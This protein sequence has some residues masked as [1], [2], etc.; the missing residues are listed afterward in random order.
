MTIRLAELI[1]EFGVP[2]AS[3][4]CWHDGE[5]HQE[6]GGLLNL[7]TGVEATADS[8]FQ[9]GSVT[10][11]W[12]TA[13]VMLLVEEGRL[14]LDTPVAEVLPGI[15]QDVTIEHLLT[16]TSG[17]DGDFFHDTG[18]GDDCLERYTAAIA[19]RPLTH[20]V[21]ATHSYSNGG[22]SVAGRVVE[23]V[24]GK[25]WDTALRD[26]L[27]TPLGLTRT[28]TLPEDV[29]RFRAATGHLGEA[30]TPT[31]TWGMMRSNSPAG[32]ICSTAPDLVRFG[33]SFVEGGPLSAESVREMTRPR[34]ELP[35]RVYGTHWGLGWILDTWD[36]TPILL[37]GGNTIGQAAMMWV[38][39]STGT[40]VAVLAN[41]GDTSGLFQAVAAGLFPE[42]AGLTPPGPALPPD[43]PSEAGIAGHAGVYERTGARITVREDELVYENT[44][45]FADLEPPVSLELV[46][47][48]EH[49]FL[50][51]R[52]GTRLWAPGA[53]Y[54][55]RDGSPYLYFGVR[56]TPK[57]P[58]APGATP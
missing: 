49:T 46:P 25:V 23:V 21:G 26:Q 14:T 41:G 6:A 11:V 55:L 19:A 9:V 54:R 20:P 12:T 34:V 51:R 31:P 42:L 43:P 47:T 10:K 56:S 3:M 2:G 37:H 44:G 40:V 7:D 48:G 13:Q 24:T 57:V 27:I 50:A 29:L 33:R 35:A 5:I 58:D 17:L 8:L 38:V 52:P 28:W 15:D 1:K 18:R 53:F 36:G 39:A 4:A 22:F 32:Q 30:N 45:D 16:H